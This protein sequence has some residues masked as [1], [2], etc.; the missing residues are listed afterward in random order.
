MYEVLFRFASLI[1]HGHPKGAVIKVQIYYFSNSLYSGDVI[2]SVLN[3]YWAFLVFLQGLNGLLCMHYTEATNQ[4]L[5]DISKASKCKLDIN[6]IFKSVI[7]LEIVCIY[8][9]AYICELLMSKILTY[10]Q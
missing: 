7:A 5:A 10:Y 4:F 9:H 6:K 1:R 8:S 3:L 2:I